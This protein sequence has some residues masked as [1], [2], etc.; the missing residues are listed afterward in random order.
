M[1]VIVASGVELAEIIETLGNV[2]MIGPEGLLPDG[3]RA[4]KERLRFAVTAPGV[5]EPGQITEPATF[6][7]SGL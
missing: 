4:E 6:A 2:Q 1:H 3:E 7:F 5:V